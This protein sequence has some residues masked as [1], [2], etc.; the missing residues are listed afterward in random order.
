[1]RIGVIGAGIA[2]LSCAELLQSAGHAVRVFDKGRGAGGRMA[3]R[4]V[5][6]PAGDVAFD[7]GAQYF[8]TRDPRFA[9]AVT[10]WQQSG[11]V[12]RWPIAGDDA[13]VGTPGMS[14]VVQALARPLS[15][16]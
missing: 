3:T 4:R 15:V 12:A 1:M 11:A 6:S 2:G 14:A 5:A 10:R 13:W 16:A 9:A 8:T 7:H